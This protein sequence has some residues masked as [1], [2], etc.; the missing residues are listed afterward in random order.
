[1][2]KARKTFEVSSLIDEVNA[3]LLNSNDEAHEMRKGM[4]RVLEDVLHKTNNYK[5]FGYLNHID[6]LDSW[7]GESVGI[8]YKNGMPHED[9][10][11]RFKNTDSTRVKYY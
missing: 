11:E 4:M 2:G 7:G 6:M 8:N 1:M 5:G 9:Y 3:M 10:D